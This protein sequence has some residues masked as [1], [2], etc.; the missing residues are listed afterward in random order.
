MK[1]KLLSAF[2]VASVIVPQSVPIMAETITPV[3]QETNV[4]PRWVGSITTGWITAGDGKSRAQFTVIYN[5]VGPE[6]G[7]VTAVNAISSIGGGAIS[8]VK[9]QSQSKLTSR[10]VYVTLSFRDSVYGNKTGSYLI[11]V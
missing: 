4:M 2:L 11:T 6:L 3:L 9:I 8:N 1:K 5:D 7:S 10:M